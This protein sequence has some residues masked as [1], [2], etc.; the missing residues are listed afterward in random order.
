M[1]LCIFFY[2]VGGS[3]LTFNK[4]FN[5]HNAHIFYYNWYGNPQFDKTYRHWN[6]DVLPHWSD[7]TWDNLPPYDGKED[8]GANFYPSLGAYSSN[9]TTIIES[10][11]KMI[12]KS[13]VGTISI[14]WWGINSF[15]DLNIIAIMNAADKYRLKVNFH[16][17]Q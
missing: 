17:E 5:K 8:I 4:N 15:E 10:H 9:D 3:I 14:S 16:I 12:Q 7:K 11:M 6:H 1:L 13:G 2:L